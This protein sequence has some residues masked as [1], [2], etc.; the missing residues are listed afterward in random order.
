MGRNDRGG[1]NIKETMET[2][3]MA[4]NGLDKRK[5]SGLLCLPEEM[6]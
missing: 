1:G 2:V 6:S 3:S 4:T 5:G